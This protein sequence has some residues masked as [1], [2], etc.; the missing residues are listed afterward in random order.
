MKYVHVWEEGEIERDEFIDYARKSSAIRD[1]NDKMT[2][3]SKSQ[4]SV[5]PKSKVSL[6][7]A[8]LAF[9]VRKAIEYF[10]GYRYLVKCPGYRQGQLRFHRP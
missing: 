8:E 10:T 3:T 4:G 2:A 6:D 9:K 5:K 1:L 7:K